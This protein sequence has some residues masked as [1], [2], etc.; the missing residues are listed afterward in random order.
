L[1]RVLI[2][3]EG[4]TEEGFIKQLVAPHLLTYNVALIPRIVMTKLVV[5]GSNYKGGGDFGKIVGDVK[6]LLGDSN[7]VAVTTF[8]D[9]YGFP[10]NIPSAL[11]SDFGN[12]EQLELKIS[13]AVAHERFRPYLQRHEFEA[14]LFANPEIVARIGL[15]PEKAQTL[16]LQRALFDSVED[17]NNDP[18]TAPS[19][20]LKAVFPFYRKPIQGPAAASEIGI[21]AMRSVAPRFSAWLSWLELLGQS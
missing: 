5:G 8:F 20:R 15:A 21:A 4:Q 12:I 7:A 11:E 2:L 16:A 18:S 17:I 9:F 19:K 1:K 10:R 14:L 13:E 3:V 6:R